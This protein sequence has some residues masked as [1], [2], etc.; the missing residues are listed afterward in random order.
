MFSRFDQNLLKFKKRPTHSRRIHQERR[1]D[2]MDGAN[3]KPHK[4]TPNQTPTTPNDT[5]PSPCLSLKRPVWIPMNFRSVY[6]VLVV[7]DFVIF[8]I[9]EWFLFSDWHGF[10]TFQRFPS[11][12]KTRFSGWSDGRTGGRRGPFKG[13]TPSPQIPFFQNSWNFWKFLEISRPWKFLEISGNFWKFWYFSWK[14]SWKYN[15]SQKFPRSA[16]P[17]AR[18]TRKR[19]SKFKRNR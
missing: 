14:I 8:Q 7:D 11:K 19:K 5:K 15:F 17:P 9:S 1:G 2:P 12:F 13:D 6:H 16:R 18:P 10:N 3:P 4:T